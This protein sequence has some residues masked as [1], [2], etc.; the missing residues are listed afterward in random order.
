MKQNKSSNMFIMKKNPQLVQ[1]IYETRYDSA[2]KQSKLFRLDRNTMETV[3][4]K[5]NSMINLEKHSIS[6][7]NENSLK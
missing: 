6:V 2:I 4:E 5:L 3:I 1:C 7:L